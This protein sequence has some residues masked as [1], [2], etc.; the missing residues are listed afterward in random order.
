MTNRNIVSTRTALVCSIL[1]AVLVVGPSRPAQAVSNVDVELGLGAFVGIGNG[2][3]IKTGAAYTAA[4]S[5]GLSSRFDAEIGATF[6][7][8]DNETGGLPFGVSPPSEKIWTFNAGLRFF[9]LST[10]HDDPARLFLMG[11]FG[12]IDGFPAKNLATPGSRDLRGG[13]GY[14]GPGLKWLVTDHVGVVFKA[15]FFIR[16]FSNIDDTAWIPTASLFWRF[17]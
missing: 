1:A 17:E 16:A 3:S 12:Y 11:G 6:A 4:L 13:M 14:I 10:K 8:A 7:Q 15:P 9:P 5:A 2:A